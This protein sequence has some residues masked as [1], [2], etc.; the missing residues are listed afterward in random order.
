MNVC[1]SYVFVDIDLKFFVSILVT[2]SRYLTLSTLLNVH[3]SKLLYLNTQ[4]FLHTLDYS[5]FMALSFAQ[6]VVI[7]ISKG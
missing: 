6:K 7:R 4:N 2:P 1:E 5:P 3:V